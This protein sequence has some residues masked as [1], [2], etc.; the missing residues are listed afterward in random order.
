MK[1]QLT[2]FKNKLFNLEQE[3]SNRKYE[4]LMTRSMQARPTVTILH[5]ERIIKSLKMS[6]EEGIETTIQ[7]VWMMVSYQEEVE[8][9]AKVKPG[10]PNL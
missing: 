8:I 7:Q 4:I 2:V 1:K 3:E 5:E 10:G 6:D 9:E